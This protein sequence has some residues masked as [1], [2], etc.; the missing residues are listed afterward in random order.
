MREAQSAIPQYK[1]KSLKFEKKSVGHRC[2]SS[3]LNSE[4]YFV[5]LS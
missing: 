3:F 1:I 5:G 4:F 2:M